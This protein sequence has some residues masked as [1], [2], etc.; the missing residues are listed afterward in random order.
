MKVV[1]SADGSRFSEAAVD[2]VARIPWDGGTEITVVRVVECPAPFDAEGE[3]IHPEEREASSRFERELR[4]QAETS[5]KRGAERLLGTGA[6]VRTEVRRGR[7]AEEIL[8]VAR[9]QDCDVLVVGARGEGERKRF[10]LGS[11]C[12][13][14]LRNAPCSV[15]VARPFAVPGERDTAETEGRLRVVAT[16]EPAEASGANVR[17]LAGLPLGETV[18]VTVLAVM[19]VGTTLFQRDILERLSRTWQAHR[20]QAE[21]RLEEAAAMLRRVTLHVESRLLDGGTHASDEILTAAEVLGADLVLVDHTEK[22]R[23]ETLLEGSVAEEVTE[24]APCSVWI[25]A[26]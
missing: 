11:V 7:P 16:L 8:A 26:R 21:R 25:V 19:T 13:A 10:A 6:S 17:L 22:G 2:L 1:L 12:R 14:V 18:E 24:H 4:E 23:L 9:E 5:V 3:A 15:L 20:A